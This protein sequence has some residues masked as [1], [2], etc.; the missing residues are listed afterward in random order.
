MAVFTAVSRED[1]D[2]WLA[3][4]PV[5]ELV[6]LQGIGAGVEN[7]NYFVTTTQGRFVLTIFEKLARDELPFYLDLMAHLAA[8]GVPCPEPIR[9]RD[10]SVLRELKN[11][12]AAMMTRLEGEAIVLPSPAHCAQ[13]GKEPLLIVAFAGR[14]HSP[15][16][17]LGTLPVG[18][19]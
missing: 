17:Q 9:A 13:V 15:R 6:D 3:H 14:P 18:H 2:I 11:K 10:G 16:L 7:T 12:P 1:A 19:A 5:G 4:Y 8:R